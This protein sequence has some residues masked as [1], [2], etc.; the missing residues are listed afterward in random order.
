MSK[1]Y[2]TLSFSE[3]LPREGSKSIKNF[4]MKQGILSYHSNVTVKC[5]SDVFNF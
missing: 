3:L 5:F 2:T 1:K 4:R